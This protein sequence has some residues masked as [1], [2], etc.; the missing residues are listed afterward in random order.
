MTYEKYTGLI[1]KRV[2]TLDER[3]R[4]RG[5]RCARYRSDQRLRLLIRPTLRRRNE[6][7]TMYNG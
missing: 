5:P 6:G 3:G 7:I 2:D 1:W 4:V